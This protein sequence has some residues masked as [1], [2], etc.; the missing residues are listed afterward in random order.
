MTNIYSR[1][2]DTTDIDL[3]FNWTNESIASKNTLHSKIIP[4]VDYQTWFD[5]CLSDKSIE[6]YINY[7]K[8]VPLGYIVLKYS[9]DIAQITYYMDKR[10]CG[11]CYEITIINHLE[12]IICQN[13]SKIR[14]MMANIKSDDIAAQK[15]FEESQY[16]FFANK[17]G[18]VKYYKNLKMRQIERCDTK[19]SSDS[20]EKGNRVLLLTN[21]KNALKVYDYLLGNGDNVCLYSGIMTVEQVNEFKPMMV[22]SYNYNYIIPQKIIQVVE[23]KIIN[24]HISYLPWNRGFSPNFWSFID[25]TPKGVTIHKIDAHLDTGDILYQK[26]C[27]FDETKETFR[28]TYDK[29]NDE[30]VALFC[31]NWHSIKSGT[32]PSL[33]QKGDGTYHTL[34]DLEMFDKNYPIDWDENIAEYKKRLVI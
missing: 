26:A 17:N 4:Y 16:L 19:Y 11:Q 30:I 31:D 18:I 34:H 15:I 12:N 21:N 28:T 6:I 7:Y 23:G 25:N 14:Y 24:M 32:C 27:Q 9:G 2:A 5:Q 3:I 10:F 20:E 8:S 29:L 1:L 13:H 33:E 22:I